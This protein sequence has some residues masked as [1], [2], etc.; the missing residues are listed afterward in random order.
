MTLL[1][2][3]AEIRTRYADKLAA[4]V[5]S[6]DSH[7]EPALRTADGSLAVDGALSLPCRVD[8]IPRDQS[9]SIGRV[10]ATSHLDFEPF[11]V[12]Y[13]K[14]TVHFNPFTWDRVQMSVEGLPAHAVSEIAKLWFLRW[15]DA[16]DANDLDAQG[17]YG[18]AHFLGEPVAAEGKV[19][20]TVDLGSAPPIALDELLN[21]LS[22]RGAI[23]ASVA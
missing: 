12:E 15:F 22:S 5:T 2:L 18:V 3:L 21:N 19:Q 4:A 13:G 9:G 23:A 10:D 1:E 8:L 11:E 7:V 20:F 14:C 6:V 16:E 17:L